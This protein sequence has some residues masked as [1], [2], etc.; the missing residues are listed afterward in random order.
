MCLLPACHLTPTPTV[1]KLWSLLH[2]A[3]S[4]VTISRQGRFSE[5]TLQNHRKPG[6]FLFA[7]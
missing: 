4:K 3:D 7:I 1:S 2:A 6:H 5:K